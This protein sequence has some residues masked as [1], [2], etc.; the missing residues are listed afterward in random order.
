MERKIID[1]SE[2]NGIIDWEKVKSAGIEGAIIRC[3]YGSDIISQDDKQWKRN[4]DECTRLGIPFGVYLYSYAKT[5]AESKS[6]AAHVVRL[7]KGCKLSYPVYLD[8]EESG[9]ESH[10]VKGAKIFCDIIEKA[11]YTVGIY[12]NQHWFTTVIKNALDKYTKWCAKYSTAKPSVACDIWQYSSTGKV[13]GITGNVDMNICYRDFPAELTG[14]PGKTPETPAA[15]P[16][17]TTLELVAETMQGKYGTGDTRKKTLGSRYTEVQNF[18]NHIAAASVDTLVS[19]T[20]AGKYGNGNT[21]KNVLGS[22]YAEVQ[23]KINGAATTKNSAQYYT[24][25]YGDTLSALAKKYGTTVVQLQKWNNIANA[26][27]IYAG[28]NIRVK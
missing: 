11:G 1:V 9:T 14:T 5:D 24:I 10:A 8:L 16:K 12:A 2:H 20:Y 28:Q 4:V 21:R 3:G 7:I 15:A 25:K 13:N 23:N 18:I 19:E 26:N 27:K 17:G 6:E 22:R